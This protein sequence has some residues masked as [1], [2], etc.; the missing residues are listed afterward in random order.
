MILSTRDWLT[1]VMLWIEWRDSLIGGKGSTNWTTL[2]SIH[3]YLNKTKTRKK[4]K[5]GCRSFPSH[6]QK[7][8]AFRLKQNLFWPKKTMYYRVFHICVVLYLCVCVC[9]C[10]HTIHVSIT[11][12]YSTPWFSTTDPNSLAYWCLY[13][14]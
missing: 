8:I 5:S 9:C 11:H 6:F 2:F 14:A 1:L 13:L 12:S 7:F 4:Y 10:F 3:G